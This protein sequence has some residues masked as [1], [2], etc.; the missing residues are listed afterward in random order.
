MLTDDIIFLLQP[1]YTT[2][3]FGVQQVQEIQQ[4]SVFCQVQTV[5]QNEFFQGSQIG[6]HPEF[7]FYISPVDYHGEPVV[8]Y[9]ERRYD[10]YRIYQKSADTLEL[11]VKEKE[12]TV[13]GNDECR[14]AE[15]D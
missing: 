14:F 5:T 9:H 8:E 3:D 4:R 12:G 13:E 1:R 11:Y 10:V 15:F 6:I 2:D 7:L